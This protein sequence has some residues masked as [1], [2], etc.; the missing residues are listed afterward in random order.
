M[1]EDS[2]SET[3]VRS[4]RDAYRLEVNM[5]RRLGEGDEVNSLP[6]RERDRSK[7]LG[8]NLDGRFSCILRV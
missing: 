2:L 5:R 7:L 3:T 4:I 1:L 8:N 6:E